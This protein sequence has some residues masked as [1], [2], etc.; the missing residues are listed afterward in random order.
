MYYVTL[1]KIFR[2]MVHT[3]DTLIIKSSSEKLVKLI[4]ELK[5]NKVFQLD[6]LRKSY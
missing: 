1:P 5:R 4:D 6:K 3:H 2:A